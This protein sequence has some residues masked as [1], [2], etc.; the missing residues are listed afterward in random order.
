M[1]EQPDIG[2]DGFQDVIEQ[3]GPESVDPLV[4]SCVIDRLPPPWEGLSMFWLLDY[5]GRRQGKLHK[6]RA[7]RMT[8]KNVKGVGLSHPFEGGQ[9]LTLSQQLRALR[10]LSTVLRQDRVLR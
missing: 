2:L 8:E 9:P 3:R 5:R 7:A 10:E 1:V 6:P 4:P